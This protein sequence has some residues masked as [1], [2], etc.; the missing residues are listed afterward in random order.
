MLM[1][2]IR[3]DVVK[4]VGKSL[5]VLSPEDLQR[6]FSKMKSEAQT[7]LDRE[8]IEEERRHLY[9]SLDMRYV[10]Q[11]HTVSVPFDSDVGDAE[12][13][14]SVFKAFQHAYRE[15]YGYTLDLSADV[16]NLRVKAIGEIPK[17]KLRR[18][19][20]GGALA[21]HAVKGRRRAMDMIGGEVA[22][23]VVYERDRLLAGNQI[24]GP[25]IIEEPTAV[26][27]VRTGQRCV[28]DSHGNLVISICQ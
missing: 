10:G 1:I 21:E 19:E 27:P 2:D 12:L 13:I 5:S 16:V 8:S 9:C 18:L 24:D 25:A 6:E 23:H 3:H 20:S 17:P 28:V 22:E 15:V 14:S 26:T 7:V 11:G 4:A